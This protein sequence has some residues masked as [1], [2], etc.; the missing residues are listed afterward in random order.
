MKHSKSSNESTNQ[1]SKSVY[2]MTWHIRKYHS[3]Q[4]EVLQVIRM[5]RVKKVR[6]TQ[7]ALRYGWIKPSNMDIRIKVDTSKVDSVVKSLNEWFTDFRPLLKDISSVQ[8]E[9]AQESF[10]TRGRN[11]GT[12]WERLKVATIRQ[13]LRIWKNVDIL[14]RSW[15][16]RKSFRVS[17]MTKNELEIENSIHYFKYHQLGTKKIPQRQMLGHSQAL[18]KRHEIATINYILKLIQKWTR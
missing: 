14:Q 10:K 6:Q 11:L 4:R 3:R 16:M 9:S 8:L 12:P 7:Q 18:I 15:T 1:D 13:K 5:I 17:K 2:L